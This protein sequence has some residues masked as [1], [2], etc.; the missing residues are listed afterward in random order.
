MG[1]GLQPKRT[2]DLKSG[3]SAQLTVTVKIGMYHVWDPVRSSMSHATMLMI[4]G[5]ST[6]VKSSSSGSGGIT[7]TPAATGSNTG[8]S[9]G[10]M[11]MNPNDPC[12]GM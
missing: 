7:V 5:T 6:P 9:T 12:A 4:R 1:K 8:G 10:T 3:R 11:P 2:P